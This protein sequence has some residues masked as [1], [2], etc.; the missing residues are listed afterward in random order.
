MRRV[1]VHF[2]P[3]ARNAPA[4]AASTARPRSASAMTTSGFWPPSSSCTRLPAA[5]AASRTR[6]PTATEPVK[7]IARTSGLVEQLGT[8]LGAA[9]DHHV[10]H[11][12]GQPGVHQ[13]PGEVDRAHGRL[14]GGLEHHRVARG[15][16]GR[17]LPRRYRHREVPWRDEP[18]DADRP[19]QRGHLARGERLAVDLAAREPR[20]PPRSTAASS[21]AARPRR[22]PPAAACPSRASCRARSRPRARAPARPRRGGSPHRSAPRR[23]DQAGKADRAASAA[24]AT[25]ARPESGKGPRSSCGAAGFGRSYVRPVMAGTHSPAIR[26]FARGGAHGA[27]QRGPASRQRLGH[28][29]RTSARTRPRRP[30]GPGVCRPCGR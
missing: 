2:C 28:E 14:L 13:A 29:L 22:G 9:T 19:A 12:G 6:R 15:E 3:A 20:R 4:Y 10:Q 21:P 17:Q 23:A 5:V 30:G 24:A 1:A 26:L 7:E 8:G 16:R 27:Q 18:D 25:S 11:A